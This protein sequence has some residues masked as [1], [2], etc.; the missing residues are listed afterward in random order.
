L[1]LVGPGY[2]RDDS[3]KV[4]SSRLRFKGVWR[5][6]QRKIKYLFVDPAV[7]VTVLGRLW[8]GESAWLKA[9]WGG[10]GLLHL[11]T[12]NVSTHC[13][14]VSVGSQARKEMEASEE[15]CLLACSSRVTQL[16]LFV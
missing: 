6:L 9:A 16:S 14:N 7:S 12:H 5:N 1:G 13:Y 10:K 8:L 15:C 11:A 3:R 2:S 4:V